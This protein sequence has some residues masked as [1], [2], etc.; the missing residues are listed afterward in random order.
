MQ[1]AIAD[2]VGVHYSFIVPAMCY[3]YIA[4]YGLKG[5]NPK[6]EAEATAP[7]LIIPN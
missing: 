3:V 5:C 2:R 4:F 6:V 1:G 7:V